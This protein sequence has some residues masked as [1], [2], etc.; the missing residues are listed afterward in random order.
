MPAPPM[1]ITLD[2]MPAMEKELIIMLE[3]VDTAAGPLS[4]L[5][6]LLNIG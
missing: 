2:L 4:E 6:S 3:K 5:F 1:Q